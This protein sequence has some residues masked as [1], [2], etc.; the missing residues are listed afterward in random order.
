MPVSE[1]RQVAIERVLVALS[2]FDIWSLASVDTLASTGDRG[3]CF[4]ARGKE[5]TRLWRHQKRG[6]E[7][8]NTQSI[9]VITLTYDKKEG[10]GIGS[11]HVLVLWNLLQRV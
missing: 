3:P 10:G 2:L 9:A 8:G 11:W 4:Y 7:Q 6:T 1:H 5:K